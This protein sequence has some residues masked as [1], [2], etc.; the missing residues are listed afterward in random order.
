MKIKV[1]SDWMREGVCIF[2][3]LFEELK[4]ENVE[5]NYD[6]VIETLGANLSKEFTEAKKKILISGENLYLKSN[7]HNALNLIENKLNYRFEIIKKFLPFWF[8]DIKIKYM[9]SSFLKFIEKLKDGD[10]NLYAILCNSI[11]GENILNFPH[12][13]SQLYIRTNKFNN[14]VE[15][16]DIYVENKE[17]FCCIIVS[18]DSAVDRVR[19]FKKLSKYKRVDFF[20]KSIYNNSGNLKIGKSHFKNYNL[21]KKYKFVICF[22]NSFAEGYITEKLPNV[23][24]GNSIPIY[25]GAPNVGDYFNTKSFINYNDYGSYNRMIDKIIELDN[26]DEEYKD[27]LRQPW[28]TKRN[29]RNVDNK[30]KGLRQFLKRIVLDKR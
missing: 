2:N 20:G 29:K 4:C 22:E 19:F 24:L 16:N 3:I 14:F 27:F 13:I 30:V 5:N 21:F 7:L 17:H 1:I 28:M 11:E 18:N 12:F 26:N 25:R 9:R 10:K 23:M 15:K 8:L 6:F